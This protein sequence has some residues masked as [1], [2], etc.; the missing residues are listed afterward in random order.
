[1]KKGK[2]FAERPCIIPRVKVY[3]NAV[4]A[5]LFVNG[6]S[7]GTAGSQSGSTVFIWE[8]I[9]INC[10]KENII[11]VHAKFPDGSVIEDNAVW[12]GC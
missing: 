4:S 3:S 2:K 9:K 8:N 7:A 12:T 11:S 5:E 10:G 1:M 6:I